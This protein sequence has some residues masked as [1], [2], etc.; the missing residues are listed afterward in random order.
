VIGD[1]PL[2]IACARADGVRCVAVA[3]GPFEAGA[4]TD[5][6]AVTYDAL[7]L[8]LA[9]RDLGVGSV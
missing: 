1:T 8:R 2:D 9:L 3:S 6:D 4:L 7:G 5:A